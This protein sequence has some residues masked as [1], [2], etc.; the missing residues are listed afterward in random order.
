MDTAGLLIPVKKVAAKSGVFRWPA[1]PILASG[2]AADQLPLGQLAADLRANKRPA[3]A[4]RNVFGPATVRIVR[5]RRITTPDAYRITVTPE[6]VELAAG[7]DAGAYYAVQT[8][9]EL[10]A[11]HGLKLP[12]GVIDDAPDY[13]RRG[14]YHDCSRGKVPTLETLKGLVEQLARWKINELQLYI[15]NV[16]TF[17]QHPAIGKGYSPFTPAELLALQDHCKDH[18]VKLVG[19]LSSFGHMEKTL[20]LPEY[21]PLGEWSVA[22]GK[23]TGTLC[24]GDPGSIKLMADLYEEFL[25]LFEAE[26][27]NICCDET[28]ELGQGRS[29]GRAE[30]VGVGMVYLKFL[31][32]LH[33]LCD[34]HGKRMNLWGDIVLDHP[35]I[36]EKLPRDVVMLNWDYSPTGR[37]IPRTKEFTD[38]GLALVVCPGTNSWGSHGCRLT[39]G[40]ENIAVFAAEGIKRGAEGLLNT[41][42]GDG[43]HRNMMAVSL[44][45]FAYGAAH[46]WR[47]RAVSAEGFTQRFALHTFGDRS[48][49]LAKAVITLGGAHEQLG[50][51]CANGSPLYGMFASPI[52]NYC[53]PELRGGKALAKTT[54]NALAGRARKLTALKW[55]TPKGADSFLSG[56]MAEYALASRIDAAA[57]LRGVVARRILAKRTP[58]DA[59]CRAYTMAMKGLPDRLEKV[60]LSRNKPSRLRIMQKAIA[61]AVAECADSATVCRRAKR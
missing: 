22:S 10:L 61:K 28:W 46:S 12:A 4:V 33:K 25:P 16:F 52:A 49:K 27:F 24:P 37:R 2:R 6:G 57:S 20:A 60:W 26:D 48:G 47:H 31:L 30:K 21:R 36:I 50:L 35:E 13:R 7:D 18:H 32:K 15:E 23:S 59:E 19:S 56:I 55:P 34:A 1:K 17:A 43:G 44:H 14:V 38:T 58:T 39:M 29:K 51:P 40:M 54:T 11:V 53:D 9:R 45:N 5:D 3:R 42:W 41:D 8:L